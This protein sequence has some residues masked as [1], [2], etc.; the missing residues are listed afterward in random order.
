MFRS[1]QLN[2]EFAHPR[3]LDQF[4]NQIRNW[5]TIKFD[6]KK[7]QTSW[8]T[9]RR[10]SPECQT[11]QK[12]E[13]NSNGINFVWSSSNQSVRLGVEHRTGGTREADTHGRHRSEAHCRQRF[14]NLKRSHM[15]KCTNIVILI[16]NTTY[17][18]NMKISWKATHE[19][20]MFLLWQRQS[21]TTILYFRR[22]FFEFYFLGLS[23][24]Y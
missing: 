1:C 24:C 17:L 18:C 4:K 13:R 22:I 12:P 14:E 3:K 2:G 8:V 15:R 11:L 5:F 6:E 7:T 23:R 10:C 19:S 9:L 21:T 20:Q 16:N